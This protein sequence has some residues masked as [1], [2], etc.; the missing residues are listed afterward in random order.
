ML[1]ATSNNQN[2]QIQGGEGDLDSI[3]M[4]TNRGDTFRSRDFNEN[5]ED[6][7]DENRG[8]PAF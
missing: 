1:R 5:F 7:N 8:I 3:K 4:T 2:K 6:D